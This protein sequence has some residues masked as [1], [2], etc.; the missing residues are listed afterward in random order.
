M[1][2]QF[3]KQLI[4]FLGTGEILDRYTILK[5]QATKKGFNR[6]VYENFSKITDFI[7]CSGKKEQ[8]KHFYKINEKIWKLETRIYNLH[9]KKADFS[10]IGEIAITIRNLNKKR[11][12]FKTK[13]NNATGNKSDVIKRNYG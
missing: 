5:I 11:V 6:E 8:I 1:K 3:V 13:I 10:K 4:A 7:K 9:N 2:R 12:E